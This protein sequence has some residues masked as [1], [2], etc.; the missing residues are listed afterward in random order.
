MP[1][2][3]TW[4]RIRIIPY[5]DLK[6]GMVVR[7]VNFFYDPKTPNKYPFALI[8]RLTGKDLRNCWFTKGDNNQNVDYGVMNDRTYLGIVAGINVD[9]KNPEGIVTKD[10]VLN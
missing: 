1:F 10:L 7:R 8:H 9:E 5:K 4:L 2:A 3:G 6:I